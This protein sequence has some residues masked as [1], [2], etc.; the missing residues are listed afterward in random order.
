MSV[1]PE[2]SGAAKR[3]MDDMAAVGTPVR[4]EENRLMYEVMAVGGALAGQNVSTGVSLSEVQGWPLTPPHWVHL[5]GS[6]AFAVT[7]M[8]ETDCPPGWK[9]HSRD[10][11]LTDTSVPPALA[12]LRHVRG[13]ISLAI[14]LA[15]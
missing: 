8:D 6:V 1:L 15:A 5:P 7:N 9:R 14:P 4:A 2:L 13:F 10:F 11:N 3:F 12:W